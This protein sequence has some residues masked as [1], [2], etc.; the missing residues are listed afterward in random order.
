MLLQ[1]RIR[2]AC[3]FAAKHQH[4]ARL[5]AGL[6]IRPRRLLREQPGPGL[7]QCGNQR[8]PIIDDFPIQMLPIVEPSPPQMIIVDTK[9]QRPNQP[10][11]RPDRHARPPDAA[12][13]VRYLRLVED[14]VQLRF[15]GG[16][17]GSLGGLGEQ[18]IMGRL[19]YCRII[20]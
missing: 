8:L 3:R 13:V 6:E 4:V 9:A 15:V 16:R 11:L 19:H 2:Q 1:E 17:H 18:L 14:D 5:E 7:R 10:Q 12:G 20:R